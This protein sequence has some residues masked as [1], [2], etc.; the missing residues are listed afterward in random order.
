M[1][2]LPGRLARLARLDRLGLRQ[3]VRLAPLAVLDPLDLLEIRQRRK[4]QMAHRDHRDH[5]EMT[6]LDPL[7]LPDRKA[8][9][10]MSRAPLEIRALLDPLETLARLDRKAQK[11][12]KVRTAFIFPA[13]LEIP[14]SRAFLATSSPSSPCQMGAT[15]DFTRPRA[16]VRGSSMKSL[17]YQ[18]RE[19]R[20]ARLFL[21]RLSPA[22]CA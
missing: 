16:G 11:V 21:A 5:R 3:S 4:G 10:T 19:C 17:S 8:S 7:D 15:S 6:S 22:A 2:A 18:K 12:R 9:L 13:P 14:G 1:K 20:S